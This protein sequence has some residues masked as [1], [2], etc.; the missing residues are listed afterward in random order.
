MLISYFILV[1][2]VVSVFGN[3]AK[4]K[5]RGKRTGSKDSINLH[6]GE[7]KLPMEVLRRQKRKTMGLE[8]TEQLEL[9]SCCRRE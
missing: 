8:I 2:P 5:R 1:I 4:H 7:I 9:C 6:K 3:E